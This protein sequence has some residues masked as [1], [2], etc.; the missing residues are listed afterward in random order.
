MADALLVQDLLDENF[1]KPETI[2]AMNRYIEK[3]KRF[4][5]IQSINIE[6][7]MKYSYAISIDNSK[8]ELLKKTFKHA[9]FKNVPKLFN[10]V[11]DKTKT[12]PENC[13]ASHIKLIQ[14]AKDNCFPY[15][16]VFED[17]AY[18]R[19]DCKKTLEEYFKVVPDTA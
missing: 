17:D 5:Y 3:K 14:Y 2:A 7:A 19:I 1:E 18:P 15:V 6:D 13:K 8:Y 10:G 11:V 16:I 9:G 4:S 12:G